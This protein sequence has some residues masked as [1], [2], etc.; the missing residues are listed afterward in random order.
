[1]TID[2]NRYASIR[3]L[4]LHTQAEVSVLQR[5]TRTIEEIVLCVEVQIVWLVRYMIK[6]NQLWYQTSLKN[7][8]KMSRACIF[9]ENS[10]RWQWLKF[11]SNL[12]NYFR[13]ENFT[14]GSKS[15]IQITFHWK[16]SGVI[17][18]FIIFFELIIIKGTF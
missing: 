3:D 11:I 10:L 14:F 13:Y 15:N 4:S 1:M 9:W 8:M 2:V 16:T 12:S 18:Y 17:T 6:D 7:L 5:V